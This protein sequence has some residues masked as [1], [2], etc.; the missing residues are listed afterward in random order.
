VLELLVALEVDAATESEVRD[1]PAERGDVVDGDVGLAGLA[2][3]R[4]VIAKVERPRIGVAGQAGAVDFEFLG[5]SSASST[6]P[7]GETDI[8]RSL[9]AARILGETKAMDIRHHLPSV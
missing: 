3:I 6:R 2:L 7:S 8:V 1:V 5:N 9:A 4:P